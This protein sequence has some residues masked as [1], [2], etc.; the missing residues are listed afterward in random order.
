MKGTFITFEGVDGCGKTTQI[1]L[2][3]KHL[4]ANGHAV[5][6][7]RE[8]GGTPIAEAIRD[9]LLDP[10][11]KGLYSTAELLL[12]AAARAQHVGECIR[13]ALEA[14]SVV[15]CDRFADSTTAYQG[16]GRGLSSNAVA[17]LHAIATGGIWPD[18][19]IVLDVPVKEG[20]ARVTRRADGLTRLD[21]ESLAFHERVRD[22]F[23]EL[24]SVEP[25][26]IKV[27]DGMLPVEQ[28]FESIK[29]LAD[30]VLAHKKM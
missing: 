30:E 13:P 7:T 14:G 23:L 25:D 6:R 5:V 20:L 17:V 26:R 15:I 4:E 22:G 27:L 3:Q 28:V 9:L 21:M 29:G 19:T 8:P 12:Y 1:G 2:L 24:A 10:K 16:A 11:N 18:L